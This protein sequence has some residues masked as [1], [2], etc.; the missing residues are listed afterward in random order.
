MTRSSPYLRR[1]AFRH[2]CGRSRRASLSKRKVSERDAPERLKGAKYS[3]TVGNLGNRDVGV[4]KQRRRHVNVIVGDASAQKH[5]LSEPDGGA[6]HHDA[7]GTACLSLVRRSRGIRARPDP[8]THFSRASRPVG[9]PCALT[10]LRRSI[11]ICP[12]RE[13]RTAHSPK[14][15][16]ALKIFAPRIDVNKISGLRGAEIRCIKV[17]SPPF[18]DNPGRASSVRPCKALV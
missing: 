8:R 5:R 17:R 15:R 18:R 10:A 11:A 9:L 1:S 14:Y 13:R 2:H 6:R 4:R 16:A 12:P 3:D 7:A